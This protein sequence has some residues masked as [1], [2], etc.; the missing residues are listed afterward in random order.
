VRC[1]ITPRRRAWCGGDALAR[2]LRAGHYAFE[3][4]VT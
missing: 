3:I 1:R 4:A 2:S